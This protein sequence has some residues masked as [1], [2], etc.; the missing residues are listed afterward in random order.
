MTDE[1]NEISSNEPKTRNE[2]HFKAKMA[3]NAR[4]CLVLYLLPW[5]PVFTPTAEIAALVMLVEITFK[6]FEHVKD[7]RK[8]R[9]F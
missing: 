2:A 6:A 9:F 4:V 3:E 5:K 1:K 8:A 7:L